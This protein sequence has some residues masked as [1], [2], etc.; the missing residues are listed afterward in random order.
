MSATMCANGSA[1]PT[2]RSRYSLSSVV[3]RSAH[4]VMAAMPDGGSRSVLVGWAWLPA[5]W[6]VLLPGG[7]QGGAES[8]GC[9]LNVIGSLQPRAGACTGCFVRLHLAYRRAIL[10]YQATR[11][12]HRVLRAAG[13]GHSSRAVPP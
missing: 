8:L 5:S 4:F 10:G 13:D 3:Q 6:D 1:T 7:S 11:F 2:L 12:P 9:G